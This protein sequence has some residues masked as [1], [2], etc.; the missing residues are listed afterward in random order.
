MKEGKTLVQLAMEVERQAQAMQDFIVPT[1][2]LKMEIAEESRPIVRVG[3][4]SFGIN[5][6]GH[7]TLATRMEIPARYYDKM[8][9]EFP[10]LLAQNVNGWAGHPSNSGVSRMVRTLDN[11]V[12]AVLSDSYSR[13]DNYDFLNSVLPSIQEAQVGEIKV[14]SSEITDRRMYLQ[15]T[16]SEVSQEF[17]LDKGDRKVGDV[18]QAGLILTNSEVGY[19]CR[20][21]RFLVF[22]LSCTN[23][24][25]VP[26]EVAGMRTRHVGGK[27]GN[28]NLYQLS[29]EAQ[30]AD[31]KAFSLATR[32][33]VRQM[34]SKDHLA[35]VVGQLQ[36]ANSR[37]M[38]GNVTE[39]VKV[40]ANNFRLNQNEQE[41]VLD[42]LIRNGNLSQ[43]GLINAVT[44]TAND[45]PSYDRA[46]ELEEIGGRLFQMPP[47]QLKPILEAKAA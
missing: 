6:I 35:R 29:L 7:D 39:G 42:H 37:K 46:V 44:R 30:D 31:T 41:S 9:T 20:E 27:L 47:A 15:M 14:Q 17:E 8:R 45:H 43:Y 5:E 18:V 3:T 26:R 22:T 24:M 16:F 28:G 23:G 12:R 4:E 2:D 21:I 11:D 40:L 33:I 1:A 32:D 19:G 13:K 10:E 25:V 34:V 36:D 38:T